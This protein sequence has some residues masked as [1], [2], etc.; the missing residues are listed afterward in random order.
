MRHCWDRIS[1][2]VPDAV[3]HAVGFDPSPKLL[4]LRSDRVVVHEGGAHLRCERGVQ[5][6]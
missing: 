3:F 5:E 6:Q 1:Q 2:E 4:D